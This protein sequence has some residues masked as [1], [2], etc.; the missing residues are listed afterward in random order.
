MEKDEFDKKMSDGT[1]L[2]KARDLN[3]L[4]AEGKP[5]VSAMVDW[6]WAPLSRADSGESIDRV[7][8]LC[9]YAV[10]HVASFDPEFSKGIGDPTKLVELFRDERRE[11]EKERVAMAKRF[12][13]KGGGDGR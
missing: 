4:L 13:P 5:P 3:R 12:A 11:A 1:F 8:A 6:I 7:V 9:L 2:V 10:I